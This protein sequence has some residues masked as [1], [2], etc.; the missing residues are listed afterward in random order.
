MRTPRLSE[1][2]LLIP[3]AIV[4]AATLLFAGFGISA[5]KVRSLASQASSWRG[6][7]G[8]AR[9]SVEVGQRMLVVLKAPS[10]AQQVAAHGGFATQRQEHNWTRDAI[11]AQKRLLTELTIHGIQVQVEFSFA[12]VL[13]G[14]SA[15]LDARAV[16]LLERRPEVAGVYPVRVAYP[17]SISSELL[18]REGIALS[19]GSLPPVVLPGYDG[20]GVTIAMLDTGVDSA[21][22]YL[23]GRILPGINVVDPDVRSGAP[24]VVD[25]ADSSKVEE[26][27]TEMAGLLV[28]AGG[29]GGI[30]GVA[31]GASVLP[32]RIA[33]WQRDQRGNWAVYSR[34]DQ[35]IAG[36]ERAVDPN[37]DGDAHDAARIALIGVASSYAAFTDSPEARAILGALDLDTLVVAPA[38]NDGPAGPG[39]GSVASPGGAPG[40]LTVGAVDLRSQVEEAPVAV[41]SGIQLLLDRR[42]PLAGTVAGRH[43]VALEL[44]SPRGPASDSAS[45]FDR[46]GLSLVAGGAALVKAGGDPRTAIENAA[47]AGAQAIVVYGTDL[48]AGGLGLDESVNVPVFSVPARVGGLAAAA[49]DRGGHPVV[50]IGVPATAHNGTS[51]QIAPFSSHGLAFDGRVKPDVAAPGVVLATSDAGRNEDGTARYATVNGSSA[52]AAV[53]TGAAALLAELRTNLSA[54]DLKSLLAGTGRPLADTSVSAQGGGLVDVGAAAAAELTAEPDTLAFGNARGDGWHSLQRLTLHNVSSRLFR[55][56]IRSTGQG[57]LEIVP[58]PKL[59]WLRPGGSTTIVLLARLRG[60]P[61]S[62]GSAEGAVELMPRASQPLRIPWA[63]TFGKPPRAALSEMALSSS[64][65]KPSDTTPAVL[66]LR[67]GSLLQT[68]AGPQVQPVARLDFELWQ[69]KE[70]LGLLARLRDLLPGQL[71]LGITGRNPV[72]KQLPPGRYR[73]ELVAL[74]TGSG[75][76]TRVAVPFTI[77]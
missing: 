40:A 46:H 70:R 68:P 48:P 44:A 43:P 54:W 56:R 71:A 28:G 72:G 15:P 76:A 8:G 50:S 17:A 66:S 69:G 7:V 14:F 64:S 32:I 73:I 74:P 33:G 37:L 3:A 25:P 57:G 19:A 11:A 55:V 75:P 52:A 51:A 2:R 24:A 61:P 45:F 22:P 36:L 35:L 12:R 27:G 9:P 53:V 39:Y 47:Q 65:F 59:V 34:T 21:H 20:R 16:A 1:L 4:I 58:K 5:P 10:L 42:V 38:G 67:A 13:N 60:T 63:V 23:G 41:R 62:G 49:L 30:S 29:P 31:A 18:G 77:K 6:L 26:H